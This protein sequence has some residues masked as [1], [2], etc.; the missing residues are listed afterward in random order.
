MR[1]EN[2]IRNKSQR[3]VSTLYKCALPKTGSYNVHCV[4]MVFP[5][6]SA[7]TPLNELI[8]MCKPSTQVLASV[9]NIFE[10]LNCGLRKNKN[11]K[12]DPDVPEC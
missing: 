5:T 1:R 12:L 3:E 6:S 10:C 11:K 8:S 9:P 4:R 7:V 2:R